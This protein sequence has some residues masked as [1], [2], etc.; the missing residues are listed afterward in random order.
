MGSDVNKNLG[1][2]E[3]AIERPFCRQTCAITCKARK[4]SAVPDTWCESQSGTVT[5]S[6]HIALVRRFLQLTLAVLLVYTLADPTARELHSL[7]WR[8]LFHIPG[9]HTFV[10]GQPPGCTIFVVPNVR[11]TDEYRNWIIENASS[12]PEAYL[13]ASHSVCHSPDLPPPNSW[14]D[15]PYVGWAACKYAVDAQIAARLSVRDDATTAAL[16]PE[17]QRQIADA[18]T[19]IQFAQEEHPGNGALW[20]ADAAL[21]WAE[22]D[23]QAT[24]ASLR[25][26]ASKNDWD[27]GTDA[28]MHAIELLRHL[29]FSRLDAASEPYWTVM[30]PLRLRN[31]AADALND[32][33]ADAADQNDDAAFENLA[34]LRRDL[35]RVDQR[36]P[37]AKNAL[38]R[39][40][41]YCGISS[42]NEAMARRLGAEIP[43]DA[44]IAAAERKA[45]A[46]R[47]AHD[48]LTANL[49]P[50]L[51][52][53][54]LDANDHENLQTT[55]NVTSSITVVTL[56]ARLGGMLSLIFLAFVIAGLLFELPYITRQNG[57]VIRTITLS[58]YSSRF[59]L[60][61]CFIVAVASL[62]IYSAFDSSIQELGMRCS[63]D[64][65][66]FTPERMNPLSAMSFAVLGATV[67]LITYI[68][69]RLSKIYTCILWS[70]PCLYLELIAV[71]AHWREH[72]V[73]LI[74]ENRL[75]IPPA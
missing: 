1:A 73:N 35:Q 39:I 31:S 11:F 25:T 16:S 43:D 57:F 13:L 68:L 14:R 8:L 60:A 23:R 54:L 72:T 45:I 21:H 61:N 52:G 19:V 50:Q 58:S 41:P 18:R 17:I 5:K 10:Q 12:S 26:A 49:P 20:L 59:W 74:T 67:R 51:A 56:I 9:E 29:G 42:L 63:L 34:T 6:K 33:M 30:L 38:R 36:I 75:G 27:Y 44:T 3:G 71:T 62:A 2:P 7:T 22:H 69:P 15:S 46:A 32:M 48:F 66:W 37:E 64:R 65:T 53:D 40:V 4:R 24:L 55:L 28:H 70:L 47:V